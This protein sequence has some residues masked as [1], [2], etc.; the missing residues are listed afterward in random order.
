MR[1]FQTGRFLTVSLGILLTAWTVGSTANANSWGAGYG[2]ESTWN[3]SSS[4]EAQPRRYDRGPRGGSS[5]TERDATGAPIPPGQRDIIAAQ[6]A[7]RGVNYLEV[8]DVQVSRLLP[9]DMQGRRHQKWIVRLANGASLLAVYNS[10][11]GDR[12]PLKVGDTV[13]MGGQYIWDKGGG[14]IHWLHEDPK[15][16]RPDGW[17][18]VNGVRYGQVEG[19]H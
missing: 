1:L 15:H 9:D 19:S 7:G 10:D 17:V 16:R 8:H 13:S 5:Y 12:V 18:E 11:M 3:E 14:L 6:A 4:F 2:S